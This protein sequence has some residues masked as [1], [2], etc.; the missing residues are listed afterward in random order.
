MPARTVWEWTEAYTAIKE[1]ADILHGSYTDAVEIVNKFL[2]ERIGEPDKMTF[3]SEEDIISSRMIYSGSDWGALEELARGEKISAYYEFPPAE[4]EETLQWRLLLEDHVFPAP[5]PDEP[6]KSYVTG[7]FWLKRLEALPKQNWFSQLHIGII[8][9]AGGDIDGA[10][11]A[12]EESVNMCKSAWALRN[13]SM[14]YKNEFGNMELAREYILRAFEVKRNCR[15]LCTEVAA[16]LTQDGK[17]ALWLEIYDGLTPELQMLGRLRLYRA[18]ALIHLNRLKEATEIINKDFEMSDIKEGELSVSQLW[19]ELYR[20][21]YAEETG[22][23]YDETNQE[24]CKKADK[25]Y[26]LPKKLDFRMH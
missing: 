19:F 2:S 16:Q 22:E 26:P 14:L 12:W 25:K 23:I 24:L 13:L 21:L 9:Y 5:D 20:R 18:I 17:D 3:P 6:P 15:S 8:R 10:K 11:A 1:D 7:S 4:D